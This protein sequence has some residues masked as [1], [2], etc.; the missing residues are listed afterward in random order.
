M[1]SAARHPQR[2]IKLDTRGGA[3]ADPS[4][5]EAITIPVARPRCTAGTHREI[6]ATAPG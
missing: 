1:A 3:R 6:P 4:P 2:T 5:M